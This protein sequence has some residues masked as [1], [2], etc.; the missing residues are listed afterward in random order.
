MEKGIIVVYEDDLLV[1]R[2]VMKTIGKVLQGTEFEDCEVAIFDDEEG[3]MG[4]MAPEEVLAVIADGNCRVRP[5]CNGIDVVEEAVR[6]GIPSEHVILHSAEVPGMLE[7]LE[8]LEIDTDPM[9]KLNK[10]R[11]LEEL[12]QALR[13]VLGIVESETP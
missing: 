7:G 1:Q 13:Q 4:I 2:L 8:I 6:Q 9:H 10:P 11:P 5:D 12:V 3:A